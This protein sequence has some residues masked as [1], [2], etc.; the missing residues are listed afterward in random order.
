MLVLAAVFQSLLK[1]VVLRTIITAATVLG[2]EVRSLSQETIV[3]DLNSIMRFVVYPQE[4]TFFFA[5]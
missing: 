5:A 1:I 3:A 2:Q 4:G